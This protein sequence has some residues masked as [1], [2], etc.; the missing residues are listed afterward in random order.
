MTKLARGRGIS[1]EWRECG[2][3]SLLLD[4][5]PW[6]TTRLIWLPTDD[7]DVTVSSGMSPE[8]RLVANQQP[9]QRGRCDKRDSED[10][11]RSAT[12]ER[13]SES[14]AQVAAAALLAA[15]ARSLIHLSAEA[16]LA[17]KK[18]GDAD[19]P[20]PSQDDIPR[21]GSAKNECARKRGKH[22][23]GY[24][25][26]RPPADQKVRLELIPLRKGNGP[27]D[28]GER[29]RECKGELSDDPKDEADQ[30]AVRDIRKP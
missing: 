14:E 26:G 9:L 30:L 8:P 18:H 12:N 10:Y 2:K 29:R 24:S 13:T 3:G 17:G 7:G 27:M 1:H 21:G 4:A 5:S 15:Q 19:K 20:G 23:H 22:E 25:P 28:D 16:K 11:R 6:K